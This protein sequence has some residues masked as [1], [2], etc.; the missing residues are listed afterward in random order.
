MPLCLTK[1]PMNR[2]CGCNTNLLENMKAPWIL[3]LCPLILSGCLSSDVSGSKIFRSHLESGLKTQRACYVYESEQMKSVM[4]GGW[5]KV[6]RMG[7]DRPRMPAVKIPA[8]TPV[9]I[10]R[11]ER[12]NLAPHGIEI[13]AFGVVRMPDT[14]VETDFVYELTVGLGE[15]IR[16]APWQDESVPEL[17]ARQ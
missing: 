1:P 8:G 13:V 12:R 2:P 14:E 17:Q 9:I 10:K 5:I 3:L 6:W 4:W 11:I 16:R 7:N 15:Q